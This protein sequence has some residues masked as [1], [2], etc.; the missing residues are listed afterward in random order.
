MTTPSLSNQALDRQTLLLC[1]SS[2]A[3]LFAVT[4]F[5]PQGLSFY[6]P[7]VQLLGLQQYLQG[8]S[9]SWNVFVRVDP[10]DLSHDLREWIAWWPPSTVLAAAP[11][12]WLGFSA[13]V[14]LRLVVCVSIMA[15]AIGWTRWWRRF[16]LPRSWI[17]AFACA[18]P[19]L[20]FASTN[21]FRFSQEVFVFASAPWLFLMFAGLVRHGSR[22]R[23]GGWSIWLCAG[24][25]AGSVYWLKYSA[26]VAVVGLIIGL[27]AWMWRT[28]QPSQSPALMT[29]FRLAALAAGGAVAPLALRTWNGLHAAIDPLDAAL[30]WDPMSLVFAVSHPALA[31]ADAF[32]PFTYGLVSPGVYPFGG[33][34]M[35]GLGWLGLSGGVVMLGLVIKANRRPEA[36]VGAF[37]ASVSLAVTIGVLSV[38]WIASNVDHF[39][40]HFA[41]PS[42]AALPAVLAEGR[43]SYRAAQKPL[44][45]MLSMTAA[46]YV[47]LPFAFGVPFVAGKMWS[48][49]AVRPAET[50]LA[51]TSLGHADASAAVS[52]LLES[53]S[54][55]SV[56]VLEDP[57]MALELP[58]RILP[59]MAGRSIAEDIRPDQRR[60]AG[61]P[62]RT[63]KPIDVLVVGHGEAPPAITRRFEAPVS[64]QRRAIDDEGL[65]V[66]VARVPASVTQ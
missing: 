56:W 27:A 9:P 66:W 31:A 52:R 8:T 17:L 45:L 2:C 30:K 41:A 37:L 16:A 26:I 65:A 46:I 11:L 63:T 44:R 49:R 13:G 59:A 58:G 29:H 50:G 54:P 19:W 47:M 42:M 35:N 14:S 23:R 62:L 53:W 28:S 10:A 51:L 61:R 38:L 43:R 55:D 4:A 39:P 5:S 60:F 12:M 3:L 40:R 33:W 7:V 25:L 15:G 32:G 6:D 48:A 1:V 18:V 34:T 22:E 20:R 36:E 24:L 57:E 64:W 21:L